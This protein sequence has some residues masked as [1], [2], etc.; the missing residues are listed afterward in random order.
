MVDA[1][2]H[3]L[4][5]SELQAK[6]PD[7]TF[8]FVYHNRPAFQEY[9]T[10]GVSFRLPFWSASKQRYGV[11]EKTETLAAARERLAAA[12]ADVLGRLR[13]AHVSATTAARLLDLHEQ[14]LMPQATLALESSMSAYQVGQVDLLTLLTALRKALG[15]ETHYY[16]LLVDYYAALAEIDALAGSELTGG[17]P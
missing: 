1:E 12:E 13:A 6:Y 4:R 9:Y 2:N 14:G 8:Q 15:Y 10:Y 7:V 11:A 17:R 3:R 16:D 5:L